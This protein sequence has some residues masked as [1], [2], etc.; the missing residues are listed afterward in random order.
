MNSETTTYRGVSE[1]SRRLQRAEVTV[2]KWLKRDGHPIL[3]IARPP[4]Q[5]VGLLWEIDE[6]DLV[7]M[8]KEYPSLH[9]DYLKG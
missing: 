7:D 5:L 9:G 1:I 4:N 2:R 3:E 8:L 6:G